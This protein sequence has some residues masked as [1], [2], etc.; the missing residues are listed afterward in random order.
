MK[1][2]EF[3][4]RDKIY[5]FL[6]AKSLKHYEGQD[7]IVHAFWESCILV[8]KVKKKTQEEVVLQV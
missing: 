4:F 2:I 6:K 1:D 7:K 3:Y 5:S 8:G